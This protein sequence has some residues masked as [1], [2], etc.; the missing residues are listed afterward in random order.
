MCLALGGVWQ[1]IST[2][3]KLSE[4]INLWLELWEVSKVQVIEPRFE[5]PKPT[6]IQSF[7]S[8]LFN[9]IPMVP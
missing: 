4:L 7:Q 3:Q 5:N 6:L 2:K 9:T 1:R 8:K